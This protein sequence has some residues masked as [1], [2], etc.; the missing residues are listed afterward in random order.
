MVELKDVSLNYALKHKKEAA[1]LR[2]VNARFETGEFSAIIGPSGCGK[3]SLIKIMAGLLSPGEGTV[4]IDGSRVR[5][6]R[7]Q[8]SVI[9]Q[10]FGL[11]PW[12]TVMDNAELPLRIRDAKFGVDRGD[13]QKIQTLLEEFRYKK[14]LC[15]MD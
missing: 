2:R 9:F 14:F 1:A 7:K 11:L 6:V 10:D 12:K 4:S 5:G 15:Y 8:I 13:R 3:T